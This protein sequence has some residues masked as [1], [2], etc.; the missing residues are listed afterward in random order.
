MA[1]LLPSWGSFLGCR[2]RGSTGNYADS[3]NLIRDLGGCLRLQTVPNLHT[4]VLLP[5]RMHLRYISLHIR[6]GK[7]LITT[8][9]NKIEDQNDTLLPRELWRC[10]LALKVFPSGSASLV[11]GEHVPRPQCSLAQ[12]M[13]PK[14]VDAISPVQC[15]LNSCI[16]KPVIAN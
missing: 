14:P 7:R 3:G 11:C 1:Q 13:A 2:C 4:T 9:R 6:L 16:S 10:A 12:Q 5:E 15:I 8:A